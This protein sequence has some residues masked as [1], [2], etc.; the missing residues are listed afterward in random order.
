MKTAFIVIY[1]L[2]AGLLI[3]IVL[4]K[5]EINKLKR[6][7]IKSQSGS[8]TSVRTTCGQKIANNDTITAGEFIALIKKGLKELE[9]PTNITINA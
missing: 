7:V 8:G 6:D 5:I 2:F 3:L 9:E 1:I 4:Q